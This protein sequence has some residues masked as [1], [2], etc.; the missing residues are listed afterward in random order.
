MLDENVRLKKT[1]K[2]EM[3]PLQQTKIKRFVEVLILLKL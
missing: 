1:K 2:L 3:L